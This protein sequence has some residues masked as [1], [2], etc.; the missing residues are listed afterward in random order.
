MKKLL[1]VSV[2]ILLLVSLLVVGCDSSPLALN[3]WEPQDGA[4]IAKA[5]IVIRGMT[6]VGAKLTVNDVKFKVGDKGLF[7]G[8]VAE[9]FEGENV[10]VLV[11][12]K[13]KETVTQTVTI[14]YTPSQ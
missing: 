1:V 11:A 13:G 12:T 8:S 9:P 10:F 4:I 3:V 6:N 14:T 2:T 5:P 7:F